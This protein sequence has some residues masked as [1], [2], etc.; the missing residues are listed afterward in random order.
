MKCSKRAGALARWHSSRPEIPLV[1]A[2]ATPAEGLT[3]ERVQ[4]QLDADY[5][6]RGS[7]SNYDPYTDMHRYVRAAKPWKDIGDHTSAS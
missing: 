1:A 6:V 7:L 3:G 5:I 2:D 4:V